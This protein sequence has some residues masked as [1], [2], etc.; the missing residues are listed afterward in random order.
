MS[1]A[2][3]VKCSCIKHHDFKCCNIKHHDNV[4]HSNINAAISILRQKESNV[5]AANQCSNIRALTNLLYLQSCMIMNVPPLLQ[6]I[7]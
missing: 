2:C 3:N 7:L 6:K 1:F 5:N 4:K